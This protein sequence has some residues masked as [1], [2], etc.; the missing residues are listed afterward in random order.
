MVALIHRW[1]GESCSSFNPVDPDLKGEK[2][3]IQGMDA[4]ILCMGFFWIVVG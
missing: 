4:R 1:R 3:D 2:Y